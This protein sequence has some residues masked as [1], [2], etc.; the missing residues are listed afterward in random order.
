MLD[1]PRVSYELRSGYYEGETKTADDWPLPQTRI[2]TLYL[3]ANTADILA[4]PVS[5]AG[6]ASYTTDATV[7]PETISEGNRATF[8]YTFSEDTEVTGG[9]N[10]ILWVSADES[11]DT[12]FFVGIQKWNSDNDVVY[13][14]GNDTEEGQVANGWLRLSHRATDPA[15]STELRP[16]HVHTSEEKVSAGEVVPIDIEILPSSTFFAAGDQLKVVIQGIDML[17]SG[18]EHE[19][20]STGKVSIYT[21]GDRPSRLVLSTRP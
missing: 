18:M 3:D 6:V 1:V 11:D 14:H 12:D 8:S 19:S 10:L 15:K 17:E 16:Y 2:T 13:F 20:I 4:S 9:M 5:S 7:A 21:G